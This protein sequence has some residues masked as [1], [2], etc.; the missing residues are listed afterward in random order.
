MQ[1]QSWTDEL[2][3]GL[4]VPVSKGESLYTLMYINIKHEIIRDDDK[5]KCEKLNKS[6]HK[7]SDKRKG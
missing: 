2:N 4:R 5:V 3:T 1:N 7:H 6:T